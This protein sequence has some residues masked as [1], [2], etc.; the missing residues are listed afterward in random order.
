MDDV[1]IGDNVWIGANSVILRGSRIGD[2]A[3]IA[4]GTIVKGTVES[5]TLV[6]DKRVKMERKI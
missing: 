6:Y 1:V 5:N 4:A 2:N 3:V